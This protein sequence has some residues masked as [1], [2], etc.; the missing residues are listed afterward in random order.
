MQ[1]HGHK[2]KLEEINTQLKVALEAYTSPTSEDR[3]I[4]NAQSEGLR[5]YFELC[6]HHDL[7]TDASANRLRAEIMEFGKP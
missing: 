3:K 5:G 1:K 4:V 7:R 6:K 2:E